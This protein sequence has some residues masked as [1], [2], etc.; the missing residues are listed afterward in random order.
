[1]GYDPSCRSVPII[2][3]AGYLSAN[4]NVPG[5]AVIGY[6]GSKW[7]HFEMQARSAVRH[8]ETMTASRQSD[9]SSRLEA[10]MRD[11]KVAI[12]ARRK[13]V[14]P[15]NPF[16]DYA[17][18]ME[19]AARELG[20]EM[21][22]STSTSIDGFVFPARYTDPGTGSIEASK[23]MAH[24]EYINREIVNAGLFAARAVFHGLL[25]SWA[26]HEK[27]PVCFQFHPRFPTHPKYDSEYLSVETAGED[28]MRR[29]W[30]YEE[31]S[32]E[33][34]LWSV[35]PLDELTTEKRIFS[36]GFIPPGQVQ[37]ADTAVA[38]TLPAELECAVVTQLQE[39]WFEFK[40][41]LVQAF[42]WGQNGSMERRHFVRPKGGWRL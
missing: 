6:P 12:K 37:S 25:G 16:G 19:Q 29:V 9:E 42:S 31:A 14:V 28:R 24:L 2:L 33:I 13:D 1:M 36:L 41:A 22:C 5:L 7:G 34:T 35:S 3:N 40:G 11:L 23:T 20:L 8:F 18:L 38:M 32:D 15:Q 17:G 10:Y 27:P 30:R 4:A 39:Y 21:R 26:S